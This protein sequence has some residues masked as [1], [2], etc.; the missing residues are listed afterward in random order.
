ME[1]TVEEEPDL[2]ECPEDFL[3]T[4]ANQ[5]GETETFSPANYR[6]DS[7][8]SLAVVAIP[9]VGDQIGSVVLQEKLGQ[10]VSCFVFRGWDEEQNISVAAKIINWNNVYDRVAAR[11]QLRTEAAALARVNHSRVIRFLDFGMDA[12]F[13]YLL[14]EY[15]DGRPMGDLIRQGGSLPTDWAV[16]LLSQIVDALGAVWKAGL[17]HRDI[18][19]DN[20]MVGADGVAKLIDF[21]L[22]TVPALNLADGKK[23]EMAGTAAYLAPE[24]AKDAALVDRRADIYSLGVTFYEVLT[25]HLPFDGKNGVQM[26]YHHLNTMPAP[27]IHINPAI[28]EVVSD[29]C[30]WMLAKNPNERPQS[31]EDLRQAFDAIVGCEVN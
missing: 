28:P 13:P 11:K 16:F 21:G 10:G 22:A 8:L 19:P 4:I 7:E 23:P 29:L 27:P 31:Y 17:V 18:K 30:V 2:F 20:V 26:I 12:R 3:G 15:F 9:E 6:A 14:T 25:G 1:P 5:S 24:Q